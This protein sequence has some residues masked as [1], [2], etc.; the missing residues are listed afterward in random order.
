MLCPP[1][2]ISNVQRKWLKLGRL[3]PWANSPTR[4]FSFRRYHASKQKY[5]PKLRPIMP[6]FTFLPISQNSFSNSF[7]N[8]A[9]TFL[10]VL[11]AWVATHKGG[12]RDPG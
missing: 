3:I 8:F 6:I 11:F 12:R 9:M 7:S 2:P 1:C 10:I 5:R 4:Y